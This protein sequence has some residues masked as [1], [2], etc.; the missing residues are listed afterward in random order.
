MKTTDF[1]K[2]SIGQDADEM[3]RDHEVQMARSDCYNAAKYAIELHKML[4]HVAESQGLEG[5]VS[6]KITLAN[7]YLRTV[8][9]YLRHEGAM[10]DQP[11]MP[12][13]SF[14]SAE[15]NFEKLLSEGE[16][17]D[18]EHELEKQEDERDRRR[19]AEAENAMDEDA[20]DDFL[21]KGGQVQVGRYHKPRKAEKTDYGSRHIGGAGDKMKASRTGTSAK[22]QG[23]KIVGMSSVVKDE[24]I[25]FDQ[26]RRDAE[27]SLKASIDRQSDARIA[28]GPTGEPKKGFWQQVGDK[29][30]G[31]IKGAFKGAKAGLQGKTVGE[32][33]SV[34]GI[35]AGAVAT[36]PVGGTGKPGTGTPK[37]I[38][39]AAKA[40][41][42]KFG[43]GIY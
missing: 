16:P 25:D 13:F 18:L 34:G 30:I 36:G 5:W 29:Q 11:E 3:H 31:M 7:D 20:V 27:A 4:H 35:G 12:V 19:D 26:L 32:S 28:H 21:A 2:E 17:G 8:W 22:N 38:K 37:S 42:P 39:N 15:R 14:E 6:E 10:D 41:K 43:K 9:E 40:A 24:S 23:N 33:V 1:I